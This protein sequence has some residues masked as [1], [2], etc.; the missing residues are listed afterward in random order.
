MTQRAV[1][2]KEMIVEAAFTIARTRGWK[3][4]TARNIARS[5]G[6]STMPLYSNLRSMEEI[7]TAVADRTMALMHEHQRRP[8]TDNPLLS[9]AI[10]YVIF[11]RDESQL[12]RFLFLDR[13]GLTFSLPAPEPAP[14]PSMEEAQGVYKVDEQPLVALKDPFVLKN[15]IFVHGLASLVAGHVIELTDTRIHELIEEAAASF[16]MMTNEVM[17]ALKKEREEK[18]DG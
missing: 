18:K 15:W 7:E 5:L 14:I 6:S 8:Y 13:P 3:S 10:G 1:F 16:Y 9:S 17:D 12:F 11:A 2:T 4:V